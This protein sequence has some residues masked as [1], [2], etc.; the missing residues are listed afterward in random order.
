MV[1][2]MGSMLELIVGNFEER[3]RAFACSAI[4]MLFH[5][6]FCVFLPLVLCIFYFL[7][8]C[9]PLIYRFPEHVYWKVDKRHK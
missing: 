1:L 6:L 5:V 8:I 7:W 3:E 9:H 4:F 2:L